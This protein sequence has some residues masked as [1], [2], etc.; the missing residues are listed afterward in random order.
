[1]QAEGLTDNLKSHGHKLPVRSKIFIVSTKRKE[2]G[3]REKK[4][5][6][7]REIQSV[8]KAVLH[9]NK[10]LLLI[11]A[12]LIVQLSFTGC[13]YTALKDTYSTT[14]SR[15]LYRSASF[16]LFVSS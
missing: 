6:R 11:S 5:R 2:S 9:D 15:L 1:M 8:I 10:L 12:A 4:R 14:L 7:R 13:N 3:S 16:M